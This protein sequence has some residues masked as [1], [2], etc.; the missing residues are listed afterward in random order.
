MKENKV[1]ET[2]QWDVFVARRGEDE[3]GKEGQTDRKLLGLGMEN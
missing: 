1:A 3:S 2:K